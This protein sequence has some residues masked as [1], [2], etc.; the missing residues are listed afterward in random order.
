MIFL[1]HVFFFYFGVKNGTRGAPLSS[2]GGGGRVIYF[3]SYGS[4]KITT[5]SHLVVVVVVAARDKI[6]GRAIFIGGEQIS[7]FYIV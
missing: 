6:D 7:L 4:L 5:T 2:A 1:N 3:R